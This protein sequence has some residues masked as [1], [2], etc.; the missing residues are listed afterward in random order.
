MISKRT[1]EINPR[2]P[3]IEELKHRVANRGDDESII[4]DMANMLYDAAAL[5]S[6]FL[7]D[8]AKS[9]GERIHRVIASNLNVNLSVK[10]EDEEVESVEE[11]QPTSEAESEP[12]THD[13]L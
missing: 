1:L 11:E 4:K 3:I 7:V 8:D 10:D 6:G 12:A 9:F 5:N 13:E 2:H